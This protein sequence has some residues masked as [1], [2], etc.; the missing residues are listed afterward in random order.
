MEVEN[1]PQ[2]LVAVLENRTQISHSSVSKEEDIKSEYASTG[3]GRGN[4]EPVLL[5][6][7][8]GGHLSIQH[9][10]VESDRPNGQR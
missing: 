3:V 6:N 1:H 10:A 9:R 4:K 5:L 8:K 2:L 7:R